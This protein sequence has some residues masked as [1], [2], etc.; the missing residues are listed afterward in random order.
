MITTNIEIRSLGPISELQMVSILILINS[1]NFFTIIFLFWLDKWDT[2]GVSQLIVTVILSWQQFK[3]KVLLLINISQLDMIWLRAKVKGVSLGNGS[4][5][6]SLLL[7]LVN[8]KVNA[9]IIKKAMSFHLQKVLLSVRQPNNYSNGQILINLS[10][11][12]S[13]VYTRF[14]R[15]RAQKWY[16]LHDNVVVEAVV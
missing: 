5:L 9:K 15:Y 14:S 1:C 4:P 6:P 13:T 10:V 16:K 12:G 8:W 2:T 11:K 7:W 3:C